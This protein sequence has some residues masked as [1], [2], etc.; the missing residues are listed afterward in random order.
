LSIL[1][2]LSEEYMIQAPRY[3]VF[4]TVKIVVLYTIIFTFLHSK[5]EDRRY[6]TAW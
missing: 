2:T 4:A 3:V 6:L 1:I 5:R